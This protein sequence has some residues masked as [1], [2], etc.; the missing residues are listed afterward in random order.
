M[1]SRIIITIAILS[2]A[3]ASTAALAGKPNKA[4]GGSGD[5]EVTSDF[6]A[7]TSSLGLGGRLE[8]Y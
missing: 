1:Q 3:L 2:L 4:K 7:F 8:W 5:P 6:L